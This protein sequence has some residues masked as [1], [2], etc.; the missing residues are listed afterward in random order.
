MDGNGWVLANREEQLVLIEKSQCIMVDTC[1]H[2][3]M[4]AYARRGNR[5]THSNVI[6]KMGM[7]ERIGQRSVCN[8]NYCEQKILCTYTTR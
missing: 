3:K 6:F 4:A 2:V 5:I 8:K 1:E 7:T